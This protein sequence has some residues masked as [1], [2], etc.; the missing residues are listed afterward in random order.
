M[1]CVNNKDSVRL[2]RTCI[3]VFEASMTITGEKEKY[4]CRLTNVKLVHIT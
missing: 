2:M 3:H 4:P 1:A